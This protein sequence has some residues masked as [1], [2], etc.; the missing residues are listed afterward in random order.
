MKVV[1]SP[2]TSLQ[3]ENILILDPGP[4]ATLAYAFPYALVTFTFAY[5]SR[6][7]STNVPLRR[8]WR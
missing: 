5:R 7:Q 4:E 8:F 2:K 1:D 6:S 3:E